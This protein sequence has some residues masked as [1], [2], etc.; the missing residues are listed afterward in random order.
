MTIYTPGI[1]QPGDIPS[2]SQDLILQNFQSLGN[3]QDRNHV[4]MADTANRGKHNFMQMPQQAGDPTTAANEG[5][6]YTKAFAGS[7]ELTWRR[8]TNGT[9]IQMTA[10]LTPT[11]AITGV[12]FLPGNIQMCWGTTNIN[13]NATTVIAFARAFTGAPYS[14]VITPVRNSG[15]VDIVYLASKAAANFT[16]RNTSGS[17]NSCNWMAIGSA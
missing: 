8:S 6:L 2:Q 3:A 15:N 5:A 13:T 11:A 16:V 10:N 12:T 1:P 17:I 4:A 7:T 14:V 9:V